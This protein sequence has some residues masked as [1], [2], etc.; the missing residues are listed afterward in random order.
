[1]RACTWPVFYKINRQCRNGGILTSQ[2]ETKW[3]GNQEQ[4]VKGWWKAAAFSR[5]HIFY[6][7]PRGWAEVFSV[8]SSEAASFYIIHG[9]PHPLHPFKARFLL[10]KAC[11]LL[12]TFEYGSI[13]C[14]RDFSANSSKKVLAEGWTTRR[15]SL[16]S[17]GALPPT[18]RP[19]PRAMQ[20]P[21]RSA[22]SWLSRPLGGKRDLGVLG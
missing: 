10:A 4:R 14:S 21:S 11:I 18:E 5:R 1:M 19:P 20:N 16:L 13:W 7:S 6:R 15:S 2:K 9:G 22:A 8:P 17:P 3:G 12:E